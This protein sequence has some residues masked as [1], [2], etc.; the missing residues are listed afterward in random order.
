MVCPCSILP[1]WSD[2]SIGNMAVELGLASFDFCC[3]VP[4]VSVVDSQLMRHFFFGSFCESGACGVGSS[5]CFLFCCRIPEGCW[6][7]GRGLGCGEGTDV[8]GVFCRM[9]TSSAMRSSALSH[10]SRV[11][12]NARCFC[13]F[14]GGGAEMGVGFRAA[15]GG[16]GGVGPS[17]ASWVIAKSFSLCFRGCGGEERA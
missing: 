16:E 12:G 7:V 9:V 6:F 10:S 8:L 11:T 15:E 4:L 14:G 13:V 1:M 2:N 3:W 5:T 17:H